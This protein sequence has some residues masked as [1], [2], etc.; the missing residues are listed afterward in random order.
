MFIGFAAFWL[1]GFVCL[2]GHAVLCMC[3]FVA[4]SLRGFVLCG[5]ADL[6]FYGFVGLCRFANLV[7]CNLIFIHVG[8]FAFSGFYCYWYCGFASFFTCV[9]VHHVCCILVAFRI[10]C[11]A[12]CILVRAV[13][14]SFFSSALRLVLTV[15][16]SAIHKAWF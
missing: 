14:V 5:C 13:F 2:G 7:R 3:I 10:V 8:G 16:S 4:Y 15:L 1:I 11:S 9:I 12:Y 6:W